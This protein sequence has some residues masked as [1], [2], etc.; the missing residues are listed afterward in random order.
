[1]VNLEEKNSKKH[2][3]FL[4]ISVRTT[5]LMLILIYEN[6]YVYNNVVIHAKQRDDKFGGK[7]NKMT[8]KI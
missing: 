2:W 1:M 8:L 6:V 7:K 5:Y 4:G 3:W